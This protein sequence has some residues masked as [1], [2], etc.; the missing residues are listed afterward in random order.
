[1]KKYD[2]DLQDPFTMKFK[3]LYNDAQK[4]A[5]KLKHECGLGKAMSKE[6]LQ[7]LN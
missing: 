1:M 3:R 6:T 2:V 4:R 7:E 5:N